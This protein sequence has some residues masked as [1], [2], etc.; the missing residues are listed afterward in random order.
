MFGN[1]T[2]PLVLTAQPLH[3]NNPRFPMQRPETGSSRL[4]VPASQE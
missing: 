1:L 4:D 3:G 2:V